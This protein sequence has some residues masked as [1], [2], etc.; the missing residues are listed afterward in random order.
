MRPGVGGRR[1]SGGI[2]FEWL[3]VRTAALLGALAAVTAAVLL[4]WSAPASAHSSRGDPLIRTGQLV[5]S[6]TGPGWHVGFTSVAMSGGVLVAGLPGATIGANENQGA[7]YLFTE[8]AGGWSNETE[9]AKLVASD[10]QAGDLFG[11][12][13]ALSG[14]T[15]VAGGRA[16]YVFTKPS[17]G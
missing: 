6:D 2:A 16:L 11:S 10:G 14:D 4:S 1:E 5:P 15:V 8:P 17:G 13:V 7:V 12:A 9:Q 3:F